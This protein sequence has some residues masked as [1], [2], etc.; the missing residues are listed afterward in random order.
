MPFRCID[1]AYSAWN[2]FTAKQGLCLCVLGVYIRFWQ[3][4]YLISL[5]I[6]SCNHVRAHNIKN[7]KCFWM[8]RLLLAKCYLPWCS[9]QHYL[10]ADTLLVK[11]ALVWWHFFPSSGVVR[12][13]RNQ[14]RSL[15]PPF[16][17][18]VK[19]SKYIY[20]YITPSVDNSSLA[21]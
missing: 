7:D 11:K 16:K 18:K 14:I 12:L 8:R 17:P 10:G 20:C 5:L 9:P 3:V 2:L 13:L 19:T 21:V 4:S 15:Y 6:L 1:T